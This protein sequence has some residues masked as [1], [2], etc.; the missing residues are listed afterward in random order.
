M[1]FVLPIEADAR[2]LWSACATF[3]TMFGLGAA[4]SVVTSERW[5]RSGLETLGLGALVAVTAYG[6]GVL[7]ARLAGAL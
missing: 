1:P 4:R 2:L 5:W 6:A 3:V 7:V